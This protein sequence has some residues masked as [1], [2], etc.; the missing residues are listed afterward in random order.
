MRFCW[1][2]IKEGTY[3][4]TENP[5][6]NSPPDNP[7]STAAKKNKSA[8]T[9]SR[10]KFCQR[11]SRTF[12]EETRLDGFGNIILKLDSRGSVVCKI[13]WKT[14]SG[15]IAIGDIYTDSGDIW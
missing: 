14:G 9:G 7:I 15:E 4:K 3:G 10:S 11:L 2:I 12:G 6:N 5:R 1:R 8:V 13:Y